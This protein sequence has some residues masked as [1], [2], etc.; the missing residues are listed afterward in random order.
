MEPNDIIEK[1][2]PEM[3]S[4]MRRVI[5]SLPPQERDS[6]LALFRGI[7]SQSSMLRTLVGLSINQARQAFGAK[8]R[9]AITGP[10]NVGKSTLYNQLVRSKSDQAEVSPIP[11]TTRVNQQADAGLFSIVDT[12]GADAVGEVGESERARAFEAARS[13]DFL[14]IMFDAIQGIKK[15]EHELFSD[16]KSL[17]KP[18]IVVLNKIDLVRKEEEAV[19]AHAAANLGIEKTQIIPIAARDGRNL[20]QVLMAIAVAEPQM[21]AALGRALPEYRSQLAW[22]SI[23]SAASVS[24]VIALT[25]LPVL[26]FGPLLL[27]QSVMVLGIAR[28]YKYDITPAR[29]R[30]LIITFGL[31]F[32]GRRLFAELSK[33]G[34]VPGWLLSAAIATSTTVVMGLAAIQWFEKGEKLSNETLNQLTR[35]VTAQLLESFKSL[36]KRKP[37]KEALQQQVEATLEESDLKT[38]EKK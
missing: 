33:M 14:I 4:T 37:S 21:I 38:Y 5:D 10:A 3:R 26:D 12:P 7:P 9:V 15:T 36:G 29:A 34:G 25:P 27:T 23:V 35:K 18:Y 32:L 8:H 1:L 30:E 19:V 22:R 16:L 24:A 11:G 17:G 2:P 20:S 28:I 6:I 31:G 13:A